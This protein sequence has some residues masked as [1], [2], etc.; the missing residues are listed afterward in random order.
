[1]H[2]KR[3]RVRGRVQIRLINEDGSL[4]HAVDTH[5]VITAAGEA[6]I[7][8]RLSDAGESAMSHM[9]IGS[10]TGGDESSTTLVTEE[11]RV[12]LDSTTQGAG[13]DDNDIIYVCTFPAGTPAGTITVSEIGI[14][15]NSVGGTLLNYSDA[16][17]SFTKGS[18]Q[19]AEVTVTLTIGIS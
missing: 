9:A 12:A 8:D 6:H 10:G 15:N 1:M 11:A 5:N 17:T 4:A 16:F 2:E 7:A 3:L 14:L 18:G 13:A 19:S